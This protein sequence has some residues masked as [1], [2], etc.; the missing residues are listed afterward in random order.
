[1]SSCEENMFEVDLQEMELEQ[2]L[3]STDRFT[4]M[5]LSSIY[6]PAQIKKFDEQGLARGIAFETCHRYMMA[7]KAMAERFTELQSIKSSL[8]SLL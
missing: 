3:E 6:T 7:M 5:V 1:M 2:L 8:N 4:L